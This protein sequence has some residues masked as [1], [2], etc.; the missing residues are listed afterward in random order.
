MSSGERY[1]RPGIRS[2]GNREPESRLSLFDSTTVCRRFQTN[3]GYCPGPKNEFGCGVNW[4]AFVP[5]AVQTRVSGELINGTLS[6]ALLGHSACVIPWFVTSEPDS[7]RFHGRSRGCP[8][9]RSARKSHC[10]FE[11]RQHASDRSIP[12]SALE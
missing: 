3:T 4:V 11:R 5:F 9:S 1:P 8:D 10:G 2:G 12:E 6:R 7:S